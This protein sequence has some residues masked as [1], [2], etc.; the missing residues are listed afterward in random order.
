VKRREFI[1]LCGGVAAWPLAARTQARAHRPLIMESGTAQAAAFAMAASN[2]F[3][4]SFAVMY[5][6]PVAWFSGA[7]PCV[8]GA[9]LGVPCI[10]AI[11]RRQP[12]GIACIPTTSSRDL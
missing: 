5:E 1:T 3:D 4:I 2:D 12:F 9:N 11:S 10:V 7:E 6:P 8:T